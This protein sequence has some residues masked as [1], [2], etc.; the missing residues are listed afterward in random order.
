[1]QLL[2]LATRNTR[3]Q[4]G[5]SAEPSALRSDRAALS[6]GCRRPNGA[7]NN[8]L[9]IEE[10]KKPFTDAGIKSNRRSLFADAAESWDTFKLEPTA[11]RN[12]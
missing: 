12:E 1:M 2:M 3:K 10:N 6:I 7:N 9:K 5:R 4:D 11:H 8:G